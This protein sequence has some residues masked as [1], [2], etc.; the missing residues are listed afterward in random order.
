MLRC[1]TANTVQNY[2]IAFWCNSLPRQLN[3]PS[4][5]MH[6]NRRRTTMKRMK[7]TPSPTIRY[8][9]QIWEAIFSNTW[10]ILVDWHRTDLHH[11]CNVNTCSRHSDHTT[12]WRQIIVFMW[13]TIKGRR[14]AH[15]GEWI[16]S[17]SWFNF[18][19]AFFVLRFSFPS[20]RRPGH[21]TRNTT[22]LMDASRSANFETE[23]L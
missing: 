18:N 9:P 23:H 17:T 16:L 4:L 13:H 8:I 19:S 5:Q 3:L 22:R 15:F 11:Y 10:R 7:H 20:F 12:L 6:T 14:C 2:I 1:T 21:G